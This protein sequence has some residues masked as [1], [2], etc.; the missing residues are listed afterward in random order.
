[1][2]GMSRLSRLGAAALVAGALLAPTAT[3]ATADSVQRVAARANAPLAQ[4]ARAEPV[5]IPGGG[6]IERYRQHAGGLPVLGAEAVVV[7]PPGTAPTLVGDHTVA[8][9]DPS[10]RPRLSRAAAIARAMRA[11]A[12]SRLRGRSSARLAVDPASESVVWQ[13]LIASGR[14]AADYEVLVDAADG[15]IVRVRD[16]LRHLT[17]SALLFVPNPVVQQGGYS[18][19]KDNADR[20]SSL[21]NS[22][23]QPVTL[24]RLTSANGCL[25]GQYADVGLG[26]GHTPVCAP[27]ANFTAFSRHS[28]KFEAL[29]AY[30][31][32]DRTRAYIDGLGLSRALSPKPQR[33]FADSLTDDNSF[34]SPK[35][36]SISYGTGGVDDAED[37]DV[38]I[39]EYGHSVQDQS[40]HLF[41]STLQGGSMGEG[42]GDYLAAVM[43]SQATGG[44]PTFDPCMFEWDA[45]SY[46]N[47]TC[48]RRTD[49][50]INL[51]TA[52]RKCGGDPHCIGEVWSGMLWKLRA[53]L[54]LDL[55]G[56]SVVDRNVLESHFMLTRKANFRE[57]VRALLAADQSLYAG[58][59][60]PAISAEAIARGLCPAAGC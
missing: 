31:H 21:L 11:T 38:I 55:N 59:H 45:T 57:G 33:V 39:H 50:A 30:F 9:L 3:A 46:T 5:T 19:L 42:F 8:G 10:G 37:A 54:G 29:M 26:R 56:Q 35:R 15:R 49:K 14:P 13:V 20:D 34:F 25:E 6:E 53:T 17:G 28:D 2:A 16:L 41:G 58:A 36:R 4:L 47:D 51:R 44:N 24:E 27:G 18:G 1:M 48:A 32:I 23:R 12:A 40:V 22:L 60:A 7:D 52:K 43:S